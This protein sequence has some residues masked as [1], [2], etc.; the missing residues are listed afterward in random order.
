[1]RYTSRDVVAYHVA[2]DVVAY[3]VYRDIYWLVSAAVIS[4]RC[5]GGC[6]F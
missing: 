3:D 4:V 6:S 1:M 2:Y 5:F